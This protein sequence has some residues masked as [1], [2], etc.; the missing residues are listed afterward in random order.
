[1]FCKPFDAN[2]KETMKHFLKKNHGLHFI[3]NFNNL[4][5]QMFETKKD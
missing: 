4:Y 2:K 1:M 3:H 5:L